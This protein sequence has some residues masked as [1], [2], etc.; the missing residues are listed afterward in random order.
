MLDQYV[1]AFVLAL[2]RRFIRLARSASARLSGRRFYCNAL[3][4][5]SDYNI[6]VNCDM[7]VACNCADHDASGIIGDLATESLKEIFDGARARMF[8]A[9]MAR[10]TLPIPQCASCPEVRLVPEERARY[11][12]THYST[13]VQGIMIENTIRCNYSCR[14]CTRPRI[15]ATR[16]KK[17]LSLDDVRRL[18][19]MLAEY[20]IQ[21]LYYFKL[22]ETFLSPTIAE[23]TDIIRAANPGIEI[24]VETNGSV[25]DSQAARDAALM[26]NR[27]RISIDGPN[28]RVMRRYQRGGRFGTVYRNMKDL[29]AYRNGRGRTLPLIEWKYVV[30]NWNDRE[31]MLSE[32]I[33]RAREAGIDGISFWPTISPFYGFSPRYYFKRYSEKIRDLREENFFVRLR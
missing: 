23:E 5:T 15:T 17:S 12:E 11:Y 10:G 2:A 24:K 4:G 3:N 6:S 14:S 26:M 7:T 16:K 27:V 20:G 19:D 18:S 13:P 25:I 8:R 33:E 28:D 21:S 1:N 22:G 31:W 29:A 9:R 30:F 32:A